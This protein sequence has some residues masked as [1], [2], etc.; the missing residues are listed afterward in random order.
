MKTKIHKTKKLAQKN[1]Q[2]FDIK[3]NLPR[4]NNLFYCVKK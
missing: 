1:M 4:E 3:I 2:V